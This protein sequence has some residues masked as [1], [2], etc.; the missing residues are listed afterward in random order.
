MQHGLIEGI[1][2]Q[3]VKFDDDLYNHIITSRN[4]TDE[5]GQAKVREALRYNIF[6]RLMFSDMAGM[7][8]SSIAHKMMPKFDGKGEIYTGL[9]YTYPFPCL[10]KNGFQFI[11]RNEKS[12]ELLRK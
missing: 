2:V 12:E 6:S 5:E 11:L 10:S 4:I 8:T 7:P 9:D 3:F 1:E